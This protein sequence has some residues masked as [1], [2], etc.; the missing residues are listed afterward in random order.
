MEVLEDN[1]AHGLWYVNKGPGGV[2][3]VTLPITRADGYP[4]RFRDTTE[5]SRSPDFCNIYMVDSIVF[6]FS[7]CNVFT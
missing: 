4:V 1:W 5:G 3:K 2:L 6:F 7:N